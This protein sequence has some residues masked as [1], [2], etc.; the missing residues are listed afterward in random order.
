MDQ[1]LVDRM[2]EYLNAGLAMDVDALDAL[3]DPEFENVRCD[4]AGQVVI[5]GKDAFMGRFRML[6]E[7]G[8]TV[9]EAIDDV[10]HL[11][12][13]VYGPHGAIV[14]RRVKDGSPVLYTFVWRREDGRWTTLLREFTFDKDITPLLR[15]VRAAEDTA[16]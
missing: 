5:L 15:A 7:L 6:R 11:A 8:Q 1:S 2:Q 9:G 13:T 4:E 12:T 16:V 14:V 10:R 3:Y